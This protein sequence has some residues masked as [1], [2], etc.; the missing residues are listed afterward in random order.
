MLVSIR[1]ALQL[2]R[3]HSPHDGPLM[4]GQAAFQAAVDAS[5]PWSNVRDG[6]RCC[7]QDR[8]A[9]DPIGILLQKRSTTMHSILV[10]LSSILIHVSIPSIIPFMNRLL[11]VPGVTD[12]PS[13]SSIV[14]N[15]ATPPQRHTAPKAHGGRTTARGGV[16]A[17]GECRQGARYARP[18][19]LRNSGVASIAPEKADQG[20]HEGSV[21]IHDVLEELRVRVLA[22][23][24]TRCHRRPRST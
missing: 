6:M 8:K 12:S 15:P 10:F 1:P 19:P 22:R 14:V 17:R 7:I 11:V 13:R 24:R 21:A 4:H 9:H 3:A 23:S 16:S 2:T 20:F 18:R 5:S